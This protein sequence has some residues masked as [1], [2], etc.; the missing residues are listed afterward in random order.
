M[1]KCKV[2]TEKVENMKKKKTKEKEME[3][4]QLN[5]IRQQLAIGNRR[6]VNGNTFLLIFFVTF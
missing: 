2:I 3:G 6:I 1:V 4:K 5:T